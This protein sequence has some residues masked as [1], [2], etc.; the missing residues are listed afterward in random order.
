MERQQADQG[1][2]NGQS[3]IWRVAEAKVEGGPSDRRFEIRVYAPPIPDL[4]AQAGAVALPR[5]TAAVR[6]AL[7]R[8]ESFD[9][10]VSLR[11]LFEVRG[12]RQLL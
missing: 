3:P 6:E 9:A 2:A 4:Y 11:K 10:L 1:Q 7:P 12:E 5:V 8:R